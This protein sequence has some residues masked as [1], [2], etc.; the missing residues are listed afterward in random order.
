MIRKVSALLPVLAITGLCVVAGYQWVWSPART[1]ELVWASQFTRG[2]IAANVFRVLATFLI[3]DILCAIVV[4]DDRKRVFPQTLDRVLWLFGVSVQVFLIAA[5]SGTLFIDPDS[6]LVRAS[7]MALLDYMP[8]LQVLAVCAAV[9]TQLSAATHKEFGEPY[10]AVS[11]LGYIASCSYLFFYI[12]MF[13]FEAQLEDQPFY[14][15]TAIVALIVLLA[16]AVVQCLSKERVDALLGHTENK[17][18]KA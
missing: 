17:G 3:A 4:P 16:C 13:L 6:M 9:L 8:A 15:V 18:E 14:N 12:F 10:I 1:T 5:A 11:G 2:D 7:F